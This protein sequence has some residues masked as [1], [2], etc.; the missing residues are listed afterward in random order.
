MPELLFLCN[1]LLTFPRVFQC[2]QQDNFNHFMTI[3]TLKSLI[4]F[5]H[6][7]LHKPWQEQMQM[8]IAMVTRANSWN[9][10]FMNTR[11]SYSN[12][13]ISDP[14]KKK[15]SFYTLNQSDR[16]LSQSNQKF[17]TS[18]RESVLTRAACFWYMSHVDEMIEIINMYFDILL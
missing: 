15:K 13:F 5:K 1:D 9:A 17:Q 7:N 16:Y 8:L 11:C 6:Y 18:T 4:N 10:I 3:G 14:C 2:Q 12:Q